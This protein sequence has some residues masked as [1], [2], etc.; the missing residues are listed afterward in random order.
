MTPATGKSKVFTLALNGLATPVYSDLASDGIAAI[1]VGGAVVSVGV[2]TREG[3][4]Y[5]LLSATGIA[6]GIAWTP[7]GEP[8]AG[9]GSAMRLQCPRSTEAQAFYKV[10]ATD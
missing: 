7:K 4:F 6:P 10:R 3:L 9:S 8:V 5:Q 2:R 1:D